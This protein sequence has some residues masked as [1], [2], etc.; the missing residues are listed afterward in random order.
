MMNKYFMIFICLIVLSCL[1]AERTTA[2]EYIK[3][4]EI[5]E[6]DIK[7]DR[8]E[9]P[10]VAYLY[11]ELKNNGDKK[12]SNLTFE[13]ST[14]LNTGSWVCKEKFMFNS[15]SL[16]L[17]SSL[18]EREAGCIGE[19]LSLFVCFWFIER[20]N[21]LFINLNFKRNSVTALIGPSGCG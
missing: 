12:I 3:N 18:F 9:L 10:V 2:E 8:S 7:F 5:G 21:L 16:A 14:M 19:N 15:F 4:I 11:M 6:S 13:S 1:T 20:K 17:H